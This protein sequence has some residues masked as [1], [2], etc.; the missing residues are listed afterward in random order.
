LLS[1]E[2]EVAPYLKSPSSNAPN[3]IMQLVRDRQLFNKLLLYN[4]IDSL[5]TYRLAKAQIKELGWIT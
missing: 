3:K 4:G 1:Y 2:E 5:M